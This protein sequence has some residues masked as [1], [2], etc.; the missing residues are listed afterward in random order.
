MNLTIQREALLE[1]LQTVSGVV[2]RRQVKPILGNVLLEAEGETLTL[3]ATDLEIE[4]RARC[5]LAQS[6][7][8]PFSTTLPAHKL[9]S[10]VRALP[11]GVPLQ[12]VFEDQR[13]TL[14]CGRS[15]FR[16]ST[17]PAE[18]FPQLD[19]SQAD[20]TLALSQARLRR[21]IAHTLFAVAVQDV[22][23]Y[24]NGMLFDLEETT[25]RVVATD[26][27]RL[28]TCE[29]QLE[30]PAAASRQAIVPRKGVQ[31]LVKLLR[32][33]EDAEPARI[34]LA[35]N[36]CTVQ[37]ERLT[38]TSRLIEG[39]FPD[40]RRVLPRDNAHVMQADRALLKGIFQ[41]A[42]ILSN[43]RIRAVRLS[44]QPG[45]LT[46]QAQN[47]EQ[48]EAHEELVVE[49][50]G[51]AFE[52]AFNVQYLLD[53]LQA[54]EDDFVSMA[55]KDASAAVLIPESSETMQCQHVIMPMRL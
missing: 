27:H 50:E 12:L 45:L 22:R 2:E 3:T 52:I 4:I 41:R 9:L 17:L 53:V 7:E 46:V 36:M 24:L 25:L 23:Y 44:L 14:I 34:G 38:L 6:V 28:S 29:T 47:A 10:I 42:A 54:G 13:C 35:D 5:A 19:L 30:E 33:D 21:M 18:D 40:Y 8:S 49:Y 15:R 26:G 39:R 37:L 20:L 11:D 32:E 51:P 16:L 48:D 55:F 43:D 31:E 1:G